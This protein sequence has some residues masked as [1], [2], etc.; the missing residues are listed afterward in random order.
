MPLPAPAPQPAPGACAAQTAEN[1]TS[2]ASRDSRAIAALLRGAGA[3]RPSSRHPAVRHAGQPQCTRH[4]ALQEGLPSP[5]RAA[6][7]RVSAKRHAA[8][9]THHSMERRV[10]RREGVLRRRAT[11]QQLQSHSR[12][13]G[14]NGCCRGARAVRRT[15]RVVLR[16]GLRPGAGVERGERE[17][18]APRGS[19]GGVDPKSAP[20]PAQRTRSINTLARARRALVC[21]PAA[22]PA[23]GGA[24]RGRQRL[25]AR[26]RAAADDASTPAAALVPLRER[27][28]AIPSRHTK[29]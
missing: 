6:Q 27:V 16:R 1:S 28:R 8:R 29:P 3:A 2:G 10:R 9:A 5:R 18:P 26:A 17:S 14:G 12:T 4:R 25:A 24:G 22:P 15:L 13:S 20:R 11:R 19:A 7:L 23:L 21:A